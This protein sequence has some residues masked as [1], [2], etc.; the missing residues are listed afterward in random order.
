MRFEVLFW[1]LLELIYIIMQF[2]LLYFDNF[3]VHVL[4][5]L[6]KFLNTSQCILKTSGSF[7]NLC[8]ILLLAKK[9][10]L[11]CI[12]Q[13]FLKI[14]AEKATYHR[15]VSINSDFCIKYKFSPCRI[16]FLLFSLL[17][18]ILSKGSD[19]RTVDNVRQAVKIQQVNR[20]EFWN[21]HKIRLRTHDIFK[22]FV[23]IYVW[24]F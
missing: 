3:L 16:F 22:K 2:K 1:N 23:E 18:T 24:P 21:P 7:E 9:V 8:E 6:S 20:S 4:H 15:M 10:L 13:N 11:P 12:P 14:L 19:Q 5:F 17:F